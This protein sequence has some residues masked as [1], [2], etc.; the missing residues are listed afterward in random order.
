MEDAARALLSTLDEPQRKSRNYREAAPTEI[1]TT[2]T[3]KFDPLS[4][5]G[6]AATDLKPPQRDLLD[7][8]IETSPRRWP[9]ISPPSGW[10]RFGRPGSRK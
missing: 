3:L 10:R 5:A 6:I 2:T 4:P 9:R 1:V 8:L 7:K